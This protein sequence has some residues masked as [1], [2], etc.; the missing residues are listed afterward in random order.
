MEL[1]DWG[2]LVVVATLGFACCYKH[3]ESKLDHIREMAGLVAAC[4]ESCDGRISQVTPATCECA[5]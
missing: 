4:H 3:E 2:V 1:S 5:R